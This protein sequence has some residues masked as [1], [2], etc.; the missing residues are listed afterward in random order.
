M[1]CRSEPNQKRTGNAKAGLVRCGK[2]FMMGKPRRPSKKE[3]GEEPPRGPEGDFSTGEVTKRRLHY[4]TRPV[5][6]GV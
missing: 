5:S 2:A 4:K 1:V 3:D 6:M